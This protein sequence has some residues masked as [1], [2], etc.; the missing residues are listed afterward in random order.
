M[1][2]RQAAL[3]QDET[4]RAGLGPPRSQLLADLPDDD[5]AARADGV[6]LADAVEGDGDDRAVPAQRR[7][8][9]RGQRD[10]GVSGAAAKVAPHGG[11]SDR[12]AVGQDGIAARGDDHGITFVGCLALGGGGGGPEAAHG[13]GF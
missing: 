3:G 9:A 10:C 6:L 5:V 12:G 13:G 4:G 2:Q 11:Q 8:A 1:D 7:V